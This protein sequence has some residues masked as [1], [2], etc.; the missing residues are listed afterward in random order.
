MT[1]NVFVYG[2]LKKGGTNH[3]LLG[4][5]CFVGKGVTFNGFRMATYNGIYPYVVHCESGGAIEG[6]VYS[7][8]D[9]TLEVLDY[10]EGNGYHYQREI[11]TVLVEREK[12]EECWMYILM[13]EK[14]NKVKLKG[15]TYSWEV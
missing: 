13:D 6:E 5:S 4:D 10:L 8:N 9:S 14:E 7:V 3:P 11:I 1:T 12:F 2:T 15:H